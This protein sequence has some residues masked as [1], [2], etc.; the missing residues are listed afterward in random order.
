MTAPNYLA[1]DVLRS[2]YG[3]TTWGVSLPKVS[4]LPKLSR[5][6]TELVN[7]TR[8]SYRFRRDFEKFELEF[9]ADT[10]KYLNSKHL[11]KEGDFLSDVVDTQ[12]FVKIM[13]NI[14]SYN[15]PSEVRDI[16]GVFQKALDLVEKKEG[17]LSE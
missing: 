3:V 1:S 7:T 10:T 16:S 6:L 2:A 9:G 8:V 17:E 11:T 12:T 14:F 5:F 15:P 4:Q 13:S